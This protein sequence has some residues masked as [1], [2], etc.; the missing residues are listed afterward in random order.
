VAQRTH[1]CRRCI[2]LACPRRRGGRRIL[3]EPLLAVSIASLREV[4]RRRWLPTVLTQAFQRLAHRVVVQASIAEDEVEPRPT[5]D[6]VLLMLMQRFPVLR[7]IPGYFVEI[8]LLPERHP[9]S[10]SEPRWAQLLI[11]PHKAPNEAVHRPFSAAFAALCEEARCSHWH[12]GTWW[13]RH[14]DSHHRWRT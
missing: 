14:V 3:A 1:L 2:N 11:S 5:T 4:Q 9:T 7:A 6:P 8:G 12:A 13:A 10:L